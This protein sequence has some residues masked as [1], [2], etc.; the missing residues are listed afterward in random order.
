M[1]TDSL[2]KKTNP[3]T[4]W[5]EKYSEIRN[6]SVEICRPLEIEDY[7][8]Q[9]IVDVSRL[10]GI[11][12]TQPGFLKRSFYSLIFRVTKFMIYSIILCSIVIMKP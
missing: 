11:W 7:V 8:V 5:V 3:T 6:H 12:V 1:K 10:N 9:P 2:L 4:N